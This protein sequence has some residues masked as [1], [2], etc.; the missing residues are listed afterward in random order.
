MLTH[1]HELRCPSFSFCAASCTWY[2]SAVT[3]YFNYRVILM[4]FLYN[5][6][7][8]VLF[9]G[10]QRYKLVLYFQQEFEKNFNLFLVLYLY[11][12]F[13]LVCLKKKGSKNLPYI[14][15]SSF[16]ASSAISITIIRRLICSF[17]C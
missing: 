11:W 6:L 3:L 12:L 10:R 1:D 17:S 4:I 8:I 5:T 14:L 16:S 15:F 7:L 9:W 2:V 13:T